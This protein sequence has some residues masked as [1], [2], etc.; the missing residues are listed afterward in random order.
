MHVCLCVCECEC[1][2]VHTFAEMEFLQWVP[3]QEFG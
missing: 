2:L 1:V 3:D